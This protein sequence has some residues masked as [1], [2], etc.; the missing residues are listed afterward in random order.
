MSLSRASSFGVVPEATIEWNPDTAAQ[1]MV[2][3]QKGKTG[4]AKTGPLPSM[5]RVSA[6]IRSGGAS[7]TMATP[8]SATVPSFMKVLR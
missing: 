2:M 4:P 3:K 5:K 6:G 7:S 1:A 8:S